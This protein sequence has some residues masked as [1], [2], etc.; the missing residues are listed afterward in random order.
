MFKM[1]PK[2]YL[3]IED[4]KEIRKSLNFLSEEVAAVR[5]QQKTILDLVDEIKS[6]KLQNAEC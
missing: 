4:M 2:K 1:G 5:L 3:A 6:L